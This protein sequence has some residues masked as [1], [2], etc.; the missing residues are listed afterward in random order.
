VEEGLYISDLPTAYN[1]K[2]L[3]E[4]GITHILCTIMGVEAYY[5]KEFKYKNIH[6]RDIKSENI[7]K[8]FNECSEFIS[9]SI[10]E[11][12]KVLVHCS[13]GISRSA[14]I[15]IAYM[16]DEGYSYSEAYEKLEEVRPIINP[17][18]GFRKQ[19]LKYY[20]DKEMRKRI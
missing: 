17:N 6:T 14:S 8:Y 9:N 4:L 1:K 20:L 12:G 3:K 2:K 7:S 11:G 16:I 19:L 5:P 10:K 15:V 18:E 13:Y